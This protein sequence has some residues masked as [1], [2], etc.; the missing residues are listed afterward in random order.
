MYYAMMCSVV[1]AYTTHVVAYNTH[2]VAYY[3]HLL[4]IIRTCVLGELRTAPV[5]CLGSEIRLESDMVFKLESTGYSQVSQE[6]YQL[7]KWDQA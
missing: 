1:V 7:Q 6:C 3:N 5:V 2:V 4:R